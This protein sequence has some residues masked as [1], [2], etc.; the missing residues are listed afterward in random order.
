MPKVAMLY[1]EAHTEGGA[2][3]PGG[4]LAPDIDLYFLTPKE[5]R[6]RYAREVLKV[7]PK[8][9]FLAYVL[10]NTADIST[11]DTY[12]NQPYAPGEAIAL[13]RQH[14]DIAMLDSVTRQPIRKGIERPAW[15]MNFAHPQHR[16]V[17]ETHMAAVLARAPF[18]EYV[19]FDDYS[20]RAYNY[21]ASNPE[22]TSLQFGASRSAEYWQAFLENAK[23]NRQWIEKTGR[24]HAANMN[25]PVDDAMIQRFIDSMSIIAKPLNGKPSI[26]MMEYWYVDWN[27]NYH[28][29]NAI[30]SIRRA[31]AIKKYG[32][33]ILATV[34]LNPF[35]VNRQRSVNG[36]A[37]RRFVDSLRALMLV[38]DGS[39]YMRVAGSYDDFA[40]IPEI[41]DIDTQLGK[42]IDAVATE[43]GGVYKRRFEG[44]TVIVDVNNNTS[45]VEEAPIVIP[46]KPVRSGRLFVFGGGGVH[47][48]TE[49]RTTAKSLL[50]LSS[51]SLVHQYAETALRD[52]YTWLKVSTIIGDEMH[53]GWMA[54]SGSGWS[55]SMLPWLAE[56]PLT[57]E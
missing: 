37:Y 45:H 55:V 2:V 28:K 13:Q 54:E 18:F 44:G 9:R 7:N 49:P 15:L 41:R 57:V 17:L 35:E 22:Y 21:K 25:S 3:I 23:Y 31:Q 56:I 53:E 46:P 11:T 20:T 12:G 52:G 51:G 38:T 26:I 36:S 24:G 47:L 29:Q 40:A 6:E 33:E 5:S 4:V 8:T 10:Y 30:T 42:P 34:Q 14:P 50:L 43:S 39:D 48:R 1:N 32:G 27:G 19:G 16:L